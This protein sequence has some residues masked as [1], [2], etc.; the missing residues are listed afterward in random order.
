[1]GGFG[2]Y[3]HALRQP[4][5]FAA[6]IVSSGA[7]DCGYWPAIRGTP[8]CIVQGVNDAQRGVRWHHTDVEYARWTH[9]LFARDNL[10]HVY[11]EHDGEHGFADNRDKISKFFTSAEQVRRD[12]YYAHVTLAS[13]QGFASNYLHPVKHNR[14]LTLDEAVAG[15]LKYDELVSHGEDFDDWRLEHRRTSRDGAMIDAMNRGNN[16][17][18]VTTKNVARFT[19]WLHPKMVDISQP[20]TISVDDQVRFAS[21]VKPSLATAMESYER[22]RDWGLIYPI[23]VELQVNR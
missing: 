13:P 15:K 8:L 6:I 11:Y 16:R 3:H 20:V 10:E 21:R 12:P 1:M 17:I 19:V 22:R 2:A 14:W 5:R 23:K 18:D 4:D 9:K 7:W